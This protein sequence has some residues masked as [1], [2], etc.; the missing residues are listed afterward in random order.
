MFLP[1]FLSRAGLLR[2]PDFALARNGSCGN[3][4]A[5]EIKAH[6]KNPYRAIEEFYDFIVDEVH[7]ATEEVNQAPAA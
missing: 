3:C 2:H 7:E 6:T 4:C 5:R 1:R